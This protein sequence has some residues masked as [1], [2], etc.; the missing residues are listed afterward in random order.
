MSAGGEGDTFCTIH[1]IQAR[2]SKIKSFLEH[3]L[4]DEYKQLTETLREDR[5]HR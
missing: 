4:T 2:R 5:K 1:E 3:F